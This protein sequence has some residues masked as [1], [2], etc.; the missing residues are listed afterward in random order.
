MAGAAE[1]GISARILD[2][3]M[4]WVGPLWLRRISWHLA[5]KRPTALGNFSRNILEEVRAFQPEVVLCTGI[6]PVAAWALQEIGK[7]GI[8]RVNFL[9]DDPWNHKNEALFF[10]KALREYDIVFNP[11]RSNIEDLKR[12]GCL[13]VEYLPFAYNPSIHFCEWPASEEERQRYACDLA[14]I[15]GADEDRIPLAQAILHAGFRVRLYGGYWDH[16]KELRPLW[17]GFVYER[18]LRLAA[19]TPMA[20]LCMGRRAN[21]DGHAMRSFELPAMGACLIVEDTEEHREFFGPEGEAVLYYKTVEEICAHLARLKR[22]PELSQKLA[23]RANE[24]ITQGKHTYTDR[25][26]TMLSAALA[27]NSSALQ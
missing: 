19:S 22:Q 25:L 26:Q 20:H 21:R 12:A 17:G 6:S 9:T 14:I 23:Q 13:R 1:L 8:K 16:V 11:R 18:E 15:G 4:A 5:G 7:L 3:R 27:H 2:I 10:W 24:I